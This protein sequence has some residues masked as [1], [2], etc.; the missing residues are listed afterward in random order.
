MGRG[1]GRPLRVAGVV[2]PEPRPPL[3]GHPL[4][5]PMV[6]YRGPLTDGPVPGR[7]AG[8]PG[9]APSLRPPRRL[10]ADRRRPFP[11]AAT[12]AS[13][14]VD[15]DRVTLVEGR[16]GKPGAPQAA[17]SRGRLVLAGRHRFRRPA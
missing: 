13:P 3:P 14:E 12:G 9:A 7:A 10:G 17:G 4:H 11:W 2:R 1:A 8:S 6:R 15:A 16:G 5:L